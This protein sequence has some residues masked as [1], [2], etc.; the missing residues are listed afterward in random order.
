MEKKSY[1]E[2]FLEYIPV[3]NIWYKTL[4]IYLYHFLIFIIVFALFWWVSSNYIL[5]TPIFQIIIALGA[6][7]PFIFMFRRIDKIREK[8]N[9]KKNGKSWF[10]FF[11]HYS[12]TSPVGATAL[13]TPL[14]LIT[15]EQPFFNLINMPSNI[16]TS[17]LFPIYATIPISLILIIFGIR[18]T[19]LAK[20]YDGDM[21]SYLYVMCPNR[22]KPYKKGVYQFIQHPRFLSRF[23]IALGIGIIANNLLAILIVILHFIPYL[24]WMKVLN[25][26]ITRIYGNK[27]K[28]YQNEVPS[29]IPKYKNWNKIIKLLFKST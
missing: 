21:H 15:Y 4:L 19:K 18:I 11:I 25:T 28:I 8:Y 3:Y 2:I 1:T 13:Y 14:I 5:I 29:L 16:I 24:I 27:I 9:M 22:V 26:E 10:H 7:V 12:Y 23:I 6:N 17:S 20:D